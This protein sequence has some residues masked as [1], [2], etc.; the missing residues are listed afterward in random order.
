MGGSAER[1]R[2]AM[3]GFVRVDGEAKS[4]KIKITAIV[5]A[6]VPRVSTAIPLDK[7][8]SSTSHTVQSQELFNSTTT[9]AI[10]HSSASSSAAHVMPFAIELPRSSTYGDLPASFVLQS[11]KSTKAT[12]KEQ[13]G[14][15]DKGEEW[16]SIRWEARL[17][18]ERGILRKSDRTIAPFVFLPP[19]PASPAV[20]ASIDR[21]NRTRRLLKGQPTVLDVRALLSSPSPASWTTHKLP[22]VALPPPANNPGLFAR[23]F[24]AKAVGSCLEEV[25]SVKLPSEPLVARAGLSFVIECRRQ[26]SYEVGKRE[27]DLPAVDLLHATSMPDSI[28]LLGP[29]LGD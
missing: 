21:S 24:G 25:W 29:A 20:A 5:T 28:S 13:R 12:Q 19:P 2:G 11:Y 22:G 16:A 7:L 3:T 4:V 23:L 8:P 10:P 26:W 18:V 6:K 15:Q 14:G 27:V 17:I 1:G 9:V